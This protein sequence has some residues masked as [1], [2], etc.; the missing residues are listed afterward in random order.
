M[1]TGMQELAKARNNHNKFKMKCI[2]PNEK[3]EI[4]NSNPIKSHAIQHNGILSKIAENGEVYCFGE[5]T[6]GE[7][8]FDFDLK[9][10][11]I[12]GEASV[13]KCLCDKH[14]DLLFSDIEKKEFTS[15]NKQYFLY[16]LKALLLSYWTKCNDAN[17]TDQ[18]KES[19]QIAQII[20]QDKILYER[21]LNAFWN[22]YHKGKYE[23]LLTKEYVIHREVLS[24]VS[25]SVNICRKLDGSLFGEENSTYPLLHITV[26]PAKEK[27]YLLIS[28]LKSNEEYF[29]A[30]IE[31]FESLTVEAIFKK[32][33]ILLPLVTDCIMIS[34]KIINKMTEVERN[35]LLLVFNP[36]TL[37]FFYQYGI[38][39]NSWSKEVS[40]NLWW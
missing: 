13:F 2:F 37:G 8:T 20:E 16:A 23:E 6:K 26:F 10:R 34:P 36:L 40:F 38:N 11:G 18:Y 27:S 21:E 17:G 39:I 29:N 4:C 1:T 33:N 30:V 14:D 5:T 28:S 32:F 22:I 7:E 12:T 15:E 19:V 35:Q 25:A 3:G 24:V 31:Q 9:K